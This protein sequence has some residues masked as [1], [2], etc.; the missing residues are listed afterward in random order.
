MFAPLAYHEESLLFLKKIHFQ[1]S[2]QNDSE[3]IQLYKSLVEKKH[4]T[5]H[6]NDVGKISTLSRIRLKLNAKLQTQRPTDVPVQYREKQNA[7]LD[8][9]QKNSNNKTIWFNAS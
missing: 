2:D 3:Y 4:F 5:T 7:F 8:D 1:L 6:R 9:L